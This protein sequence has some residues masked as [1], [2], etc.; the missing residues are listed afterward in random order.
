M[1]STLPATGAL[2]NTAFTYDSVVGLKW[3]A[4]NL[5]LHNSIDAGLYFDSTTIVSPAV[6]IATIFDQTCGTQFTSTDGAA[7][8]LF[9]CG[10]LDAN[11]KL[12]LYAHDATPS[13]CVAVGSLKV[14]A[15]ETCSVDLMDFSI[16]ARQQNVNVVPRDPVSDPRY[17]TITN[18][19]DS[20][21]SL[22]LSGL[23]DAKDFCYANYLSDFIFRNPDGGSG[24]AFEQDEDGPV[25]L[26]TYNLSPKSRK[27]R[28]NSLGIEA[29]VYGDCSVGFLRDG[30]RGF[31]QDCSMVHYSTYMGPSLG[32]YSEPQ[33]GCDQNI[34][35]F[36]VETVDTDVE[37]CQST[38]TTSAT[39]AATSA[40]TTPPSYPT[41]TPG[42]NPG[43]YFEYFGCVGSTSEFDGFLQKLNTDDMTVE[44]CQNACTGYEYAALHGR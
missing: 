11:P 41:Q 1:S 20:G 6:G 40:T 5:R 26:Q 43:D 38:S 44:K 22:A 18:A 4:N 19:E 32:V 34:E 13:G 42:P 24:L 2:Q 35:L 3:L 10:D 21:P 28:R 7:T 23:C 16:E 17:V 8:K 27:V 15:I 25:F 29:V 9:V 31:I 14:K 39:S 37:Q 36:I 12:S 30:S 33:N